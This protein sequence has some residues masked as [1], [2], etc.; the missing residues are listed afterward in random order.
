VNEL[1]KIE[2]IA[3][4]PGLEKNTY[5]NGKIDLDVKDYAKKL[6]MEHIPLKRIHDLTGI[7][8]NTLSQFANQGDNSWRAQR[9]IFCEAIIQ[10]FSESKKAQ[11]TRIM[12]YTLENLSRALKALA[13]RKEPPTI[14]EAEGVS[15]IYDSLDKIMRLDSGTPTDILQR[16]KPSSVIE[17]SKKIKEQLGTDPWAET[18]AEYHELEPS[19]K[20]AVD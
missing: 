18:I 11:L 8:Y 16:V 17:L 3:Y 10:N 15:R 14:K 6:Y 4:C 9:E 13:D 7:N 19:T 1:E 2:E 20:P 12:S 5:V